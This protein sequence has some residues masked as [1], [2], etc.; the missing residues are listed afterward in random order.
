MNRKRIYFGVSAEQNRPK[1]NCRLF[2]CHNLLSISILGRFFSLQNC[3]TL[4]IK[5]LGAGAAPPPSVRPYPLS[6]MKRNLGLLIL[7]GGP[8]F[9]SP[10]RLLIVHKSFNQKKSHV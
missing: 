7:V 10:K 3:N 1:I 6:E 8:F 4:D 2:L 5:G 9:Q